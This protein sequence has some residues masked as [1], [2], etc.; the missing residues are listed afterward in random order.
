[1]SQGFVPPPAA[2]RPQQGGVPYGQVVPAQQARPQ[3]PPPPAAPAS[4]PETIS[5][6]V[7]GAVPQLP[8]LS[9]IVQT[10]DMIARKLPW[11]VWLLLGVFGVRGAAWFVPR[12][13][14]KAA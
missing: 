5:R 6:A 8:A 14:R 11:Y 4:M 9:S 12:W 10:V 2:P 13:F 1:M 3:Q 7:D